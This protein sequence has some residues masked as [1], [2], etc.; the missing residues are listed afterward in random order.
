MDSTETGILEGHIKVGPGDVNMEGIVSILKQ[1][2]AFV[3]MQGA[4]E[5]LIEQ[6]EIALGLR[7]AK[8]Y[9]A[10][11]KA[12]GAASFYGHELTG[13]CNAHQLNVVEVSLSER[14]YNH[15]IPEEWYVV[16]QVHIDGIVIWQSTKG[17]IFKS[18]PNAK[19]VKV[20]DSLVEYVNM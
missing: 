2:D 10:Y 12:F 11:V 16:E 20:C 1:K 5:R 15:D 3:S 6:S 8:D 14:Q 7:F 9:T 13:V 19:P 4:T 18:I 17:H